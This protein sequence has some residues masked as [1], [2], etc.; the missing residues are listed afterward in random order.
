MQTTPHMKGKTGAPASAPLLSLCMIVKNE[1]RVLA[2]CLQSV[3]G[4][5]DE[6]IVV[7]TGSTDRTVEI[8]Q[9]YNAKIFHFPWN[10]S[11]SDARNEAL[12]HCTCA[13][14]IYLD[15]D[16]RLETRDRDRL[17][18]LVRRP[19]ADA[20]EITVVSRRTEGKRVIRNTSDQPRLFRRDPRYRFRFRIHESILPSVRETGGVVAKENITLHHV[21]YDISNEAMERKQLRNYE[22]LVIDVQEY[23]YD[24]FVLKKFAQTLVALGKTAEAAEQLNDILKRIDSGRCGDVSRPTRAAFCNLYVDALMKTG[25]FVGAHFWASESLRTLKA[26]NA[27][28]F[29]L[30]LI[31]ER[32]EKFDEALVHLN[33][34]VL[35]KKDETIPVAEDDVMPTP[36]DVCY[37]R[38]T[39]YRAMKKPLD[40]RRELVSALRFEPGMTAA[41]HD[42][43]AF[44]A[45]EKNFI[46]ALSLITKARET[47]PSNGSVLHLRALILF[48]LQRKEEALHDAA[49]AFRCGETG[50]A[51]LVF[52][53]QA[54]KEAGKETEALP[55]Y[56]LIAERHPDA[57]DMVI[58][59]IQQLVQARDLA[60]AIAVIERSLPLVND[61]SL[62]TVLKAIYAKLAPVAGNLL[63]V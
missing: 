11:F 31:N 30:T 14:V 39:L 3:R 33:A 52:W 42:L 18:N 1:E 20:Y 38:A 55:A 23:P 45:R 27:A 40:E 47:D 50:D 5:V 62:R 10:G 37:K 26:Q 57:G 58:A 25:D 29:Y 16:E 48:Q 59:Y 43:A 41:L 6:I 21:G 63:S 7:D 28:R 34:I 17:R 35:Q 4:V 2:D 51:L 44:M 61:A 9:S 13:Y 8:A 32:L 12:A 53:I 49:L 56:A 19:G 60:T 46:Q 15:A 36:Q 22:Q 24:L 54:A